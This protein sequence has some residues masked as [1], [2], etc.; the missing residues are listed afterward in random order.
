MFQQ[1]MA[2]SYESHIM[3][4]DFCIINTLQ[5]S[6][7]HSGAELFPGPQSGKQNNIPDGG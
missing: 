6:K 3:M 7:C 1:N 2:F 5:L 4:G